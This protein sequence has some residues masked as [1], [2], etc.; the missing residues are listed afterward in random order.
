MQRAI[1][2]VG[3]VK[4]ERHLAGTWITRRRIDTRRIKQSIALDCDPGGETHVRVG[5]IGAGPVLQT[6][7]SLNQAFSMKHS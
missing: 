5:H 2:I 7:Y 3:V 6:I 1:V 4:Q